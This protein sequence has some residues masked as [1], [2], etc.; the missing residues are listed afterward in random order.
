MMLSNHF[1]Q[2][3]IILPV[4]DRVT[5]L[6]VSKSL[7]FLMESLNWTREQIDAFQN[8][9]LRLLI[10]HAY[11][12]VPY[13]HDLFDRLG[14]RPSDI[15]VKED[16][17]RLPILTK[18]IIKQEGTERFLATNIPHRK[19]IKA[20]SSGSTGEP[21]IYYRT[22]D[23][24]SMSIASHLRGWY[25]MGYRLGDRFA[26]LSQ[27]ARKSK[28]KLV[29][30]WFSNNLYLPTS[31]LTDEN[32]EYILRKIEQYKP[33]VIRCYPDPLLLL[34]R[35]KRKHPEYTYSPDAITTTG[36]TLHDKDREVI[37]DT[38]NCKIFD[39]YGCE[40]TANI[41][42]CTSHGCY[43]STEEYGISEI[44]DKEGHTVQQGVGQLISTDLWNYAHPF[45]RYNTQDMV[46][47]DDGVCACDMAHLKVRR[48]LGRDTDVLEMPSGKK[49]SV[50]E[51]IFLVDKAELNRAVEQY[52]VIKRKDNS[53]L[54]RLVVNDRYTPE[55]E[56]YIIDFWQK[57]FEVPVSIEVV[58]EIPIMQ[59]NKRR[60]IINEQ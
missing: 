50:Y 19:M 32:F 53:V 18:T 59:N 39:A 23:A 56:K 55:V 6:S 21:L 10:E 11:N 45:I 28:L 36:Q 58:P 4:S 12:H 30:D 3:R 9:R 38:F 24:N 8:E 13:Y 48:I 1:I 49:F 57:E 27:G 51:F 31:P 20:A 60:F 15:R 35:Y 47:V 29:Q 2:E 14:I 41:F 40:G 43:Y 42:E 54:F 34:A 44:L 37:E 22:K 46:E 16:L 33:S 5:G 17:A 25:S 26:K 52:Q 7:R